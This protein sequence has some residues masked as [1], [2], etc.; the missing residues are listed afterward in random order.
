MSRVT[1]GAS[2]RRTRL[3]EMMQM[4]NLG[5]GAS[6]NEIQGYM[7]ARFG[8]KHTTTRKYVMEAHLGG[9]LREDHG[10]WFITDRYVRLKPLKGRHDL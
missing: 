9:F 10:R 6:M 8:L 2:L 7:W 1:N 4:I 5:K 3:L